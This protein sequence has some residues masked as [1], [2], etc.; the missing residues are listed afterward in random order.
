MSDGNYI[1]PLFPWIAVLGKLAGLPTKINL[2][3]TWTYELSRGKWMLGSGRL[4][5]LEDVGSR[6][7]TAWKGG[8][9]LALHTR[10]TSDTPPYT[11][12]TRNRRPNERFHRKRSKVAADRL[13]LYQCTATR[14]PPVRAPHDLRGS[15]LCT[16][17]HKHRSCPCIFE[18]GSTKMATGITSCE[19]FFPLSFMNILYCGDKTGMI[20]NMTSCYYK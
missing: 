16:R 11:I 6:Q 12:C 9:S 10:S 15:P 18:A 4:L 20:T 14:N 17:K 19:F 2:Y 8:F 1:Q 7:Y 3:L 13:P 5:H